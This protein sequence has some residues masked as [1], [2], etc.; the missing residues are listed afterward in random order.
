M[1]EDLLAMIKLRMR[2]IHGFDRNRKISSQIGSEGL[3]TATQYTLK[4]KSID[5]IEQRQTLHLSQVAAHEVI[6]KFTFLRDSASLRK[7]LHKLLHSN[8]RHF[9]RKALHK[10]SSLRHYSPAYTSCECNSDIQLIKQ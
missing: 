3:L 6:N 5:Y 10:V 9:A 8:H 1:D 4:K 7:E 2:C